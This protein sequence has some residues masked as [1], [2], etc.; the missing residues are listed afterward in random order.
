MANKKRRAPSRR[1]VKRAA[2]LVVGGTLAAALMGIGAGMLVEKLSK[3]LGADLKG[4]GPIIGPVAAFG[5]GG[6]PGGLGQLV[7]GSLPDFF[8]GAQDKPSRSTV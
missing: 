1:R 8:G 3:N 7:V 6:V 5:V 4:F 2:K